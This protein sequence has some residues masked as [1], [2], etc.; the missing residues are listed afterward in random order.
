SA[1]GLGANAAPRRAASEQPV[2]DRVYVVGIEPLEG[3]ADSWATPAGITCRL[4]DPLLNLRDPGHRPRETG[5]GLKHT[6]KEPPQGADRRVGLDGEVYRCLSRHPL[7]A[8]KQHASLVVE[9]P[10]LSV[11]Q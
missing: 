6:R 11:T 8:G 2:T 7:G 3:P 1:A 4:Y 10:R 9:E 5:M